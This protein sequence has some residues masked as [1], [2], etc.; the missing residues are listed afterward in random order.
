[1]E[2]KNIGPRAFQDKQLPSEAKQLISA[3]VVRVIIPLPSHVTE[4]T[5]AAQVTLSCRLLFPPL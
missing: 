4:A 5:G 1:M 3:H 2:K